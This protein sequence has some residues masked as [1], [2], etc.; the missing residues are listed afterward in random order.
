MKA[1]GGTVLVA[2][3]LAL[4]L[5]AATAPAATYTVNSTADTGDAS[6]DGTCDLCTLREAIQESNNSGGTADIIAFT[7]TLAI[8]LGGDLPAITDPVTI[9][10]G[11]TP[12]TNAGFTALNTVLNVTVDAND[13]A[14]FLVNAAST[15]IKGLVIQD[16][17]DES[18]GSAVPEVDMI[19]LN[20]NSNRV[21]GNFIGTNAAGTADFGKGGAGVVIL[22]GTGNTVGGSTAAQRNLISG[23]GFEL[24][25]DPNHPGYG[26]WVKGGSGA[27]IAGNIIG[28]DKT[29]TA[30][31]MHNM[32]SG[33]RVG[34]QGSAAPNTTVGPGNLLSGNGG[35]IPGN[36]ID[37]GDQAGTGTKI[38]ANRIGTNIAGTAALPNNSHG[39]EVF[40]DAEVDV[41][42][43]GAGDGNLISGNN[44]YGIDMSGDGN[45]AE[46][47]LIGLDADGTSA[48]PNQVGIRARGSNHTI[49][50]VGGPRNT[51]S[52]NRSHG[53]W[54][55]DDPVQMVVEGNF[56]GTN[57]AGTA[58]VP[59]G[60]SGVQVEGGDQNTIGTVPFSLGGN[61]I[62]GNVGP[63]IALV[64]PEGPS[65]PESTEVNGN[66]IGTDASGITPIG[67]G[68]EGVFMQNAL[69]TAIGQSASVNNIVAFNGGAGIRVQDDGAPGA[70]GDTFTGNS[71]YSNGGLGI[72]LTPGS[73]VT[74]NDALDLDAGANRLQNFP[75]LDMTPPFS[76]TSVSG[77]LS[78]APNAD[79]DVDFYSVTQCDVSDHGEGKTY[80][81]QE[82]VST[83]G[84]GVA[85]FT[86]TLTPPI[87]STEGV[88]ATATGDDG[89]SEFSEC[90]GAK[91]PK[92][93]QQHPPT[94]TTSVLPH[95]PATVTPARCK[96]RKPPI[97]KL[98]RKGLSGIGTSKLRLKGKARDRKGCPSGLR[99]V[100]I[101]LAR[102]R[103]RSG[104][105]CRFIR[106][107][108]RY[109][110]TH[111]Q[112][113]R[114]PILFRATG[115]RKWTFNFPVDLRAGT[116]RVQ[117]RATDKAGNKETP[118]KRRNIVFFT[119]P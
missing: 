77:T 58:S 102:V 33:V 45:V 1:L 68:G 4:A 98:K 86:H 47:N 3:A 119:V 37:V 31:D 107:P 103:G 19:T 28:A 104:V 10:G 41:G 53:I 25:S 70:T 72:D 108:G 24:A 56:V 30:A 36:G 51:V 69:N 8:Q 20:G 78:S 63:G 62:S 79:F 92:P 84:S 93:P 110:L 64:K 18:T 17:S 50:G 96:D 43:P 114:R 76:T 6:P 90:R 13:H 85:T 100:Q 27:T 112:N 2:L 61:L 95:T 83:D 66:R 39:V 38:I 29:G 15:T 113:C 89:T 55:P 91:L 99:K 9:D 12:N 23:N 118:K 22:S 82:S 26:V 16:T 40:N 74:L 42:G 52:G 115:R 116:Y 59:N 32:F 60:G 109:Q 34:G 35:S 46:G 65:G 57:F 67:N 88:T 49:G 117:A 54:L 80:L 106:Q 71:V 48:I 87:G 81:G 21:E 75:S 111:P 97:T 44:L 101:S 7:G 94:T 73:G 11:G 5:G 105:N 14:A